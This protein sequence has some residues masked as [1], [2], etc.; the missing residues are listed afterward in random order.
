MHP[1][2][3]A[4]AITLIF[5]LMVP[6]S[7]SMGGTYNRAGRVGPDRETA[8]ALACHCA[9]LNSVR[10]VTAAPNPAPGTGGDRHVAERG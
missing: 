3:A 2:A 9:G 4:I 7:K 8:P 6:S 5:I 1:T 10:A